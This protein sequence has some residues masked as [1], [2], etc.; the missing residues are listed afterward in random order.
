M[1]IGMQ[2]RHQSDF[3][4]PHA[5]DGHQI[6]LIDHARP[7]P[8]RVKVLPDLRIACLAIDVERRVPNERM[9]LDAQPLLVHFVDEGETMAKIKIGNHRRQVVGD[10]LQ[11]ILTRLHCCG[12]LQHRLC[13]TVERRCQSADLPALA[14][15]AAVC[16]LTA[17][18]GSRVFAEPAA[19]VSGCRRVM[20]VFDDSGGQISVRELGR[21]GAWCFDDI[22]L[23]RHLA[24]SAS[25][26]RA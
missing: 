8:R 25:S 23:S 13:G 12:P 17:F 4:A 21:G 2:M 3:N 11:L 18:K 16:E 19:S 20:S 7:K 5:V 22:R 24:H 9:S 26:N 1:P 15:V 6:A 14:D 10:L